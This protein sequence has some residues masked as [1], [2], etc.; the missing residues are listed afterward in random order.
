VGVCAATVVITLVLTSSVG[1]TVRTAT[2]TQAG[3]PPYSPSVQV[4]GAERE[5]LRDYIAVP[6]HRTQL[7]SL[8]E[9]SFKQAGVRT[10]TNRESSPEQ[11]TLGPCNATRM[12]HDKH[13]QE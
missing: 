6:E 4:A 10:G 5:Q 12:P 9:R 13:R 11:D 7:S 1:Q 8:V 3:A 2:T